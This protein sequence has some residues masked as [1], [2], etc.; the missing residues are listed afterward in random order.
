MVK[1]RCFD[2][3]VKLMQSKQVLTLNRH[4]E[5]QFALSTSDFVAQSC[6]QFQ[7]SFG[8]FV[9]Q[10][11]LD[12]TDHSIVLMLDQLAAS[13]LLR[14]GNRDIPEIHHRDCAPL[15]LTQAS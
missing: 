5:S 9:N 3:E 10:A 7:L 12:S 11:L 15:L 8:E 1:H 4:L 13:P 6:L 2:A 14:Q